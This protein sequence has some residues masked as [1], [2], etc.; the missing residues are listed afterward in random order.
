MNR[1]SLTGHG[2]DTARFRQ[3][4]GQEP[5]RA[6]DENDQFDVHI[7]LQVRNLDVQERCCDNPMERM[8][9][10]K[11]LEL[12]ICSPEYKEANHAAGI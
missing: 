9:A 3:S 10:N 12:L 8:S 7:G 1:A 5:D 11:S 2:A 4:P 6:G